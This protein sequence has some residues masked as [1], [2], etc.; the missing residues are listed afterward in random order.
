MTREIR[1]KSFKSYFKKL[2]IVIY[3]FQILKEN[4][5]N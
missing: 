3:R 5:N 2:F 1:I 4:R